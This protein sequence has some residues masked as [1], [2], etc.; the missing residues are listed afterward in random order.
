[1]ELT[2]T[3]LAPATWAPFEVH[4]DYQTRLWSL[5]MNGAIVADHFAFFSDTRDHLGEF[6]VKSTSETGPS[7]IDSVVA[8]GSPATGIVFI[9]R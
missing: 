4:L 7:Y 8:T 1:M 3:T 5:K 2:A 6:H 9:V